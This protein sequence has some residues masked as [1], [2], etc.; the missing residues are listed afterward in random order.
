[1]IATVVNLRY[2]LGCPLSVHHCCNH[3]TLK[4]ICDKPM[5]LHCR[6]HCESY[7]AMFIGTNVSEVGIII[8]SKRSV[9]VPRPPCPQVAMP[10]FSLVLTHPGTTS[11]SFKAKEQPFWKLHESAST[12]RPWGISQFTRY[13]GIW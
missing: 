2:P 6:Q 5:D 4:Q 12:L 10:P 7:V 13:G 8:I 9:P 11:H 3:D 1:M